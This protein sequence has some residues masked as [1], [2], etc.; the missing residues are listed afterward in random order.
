MH[1][2]P[3]PPEKSSP[4]RNSWAVAFSAGSELVVAVLLGFFCGRW[5]DG[6]F[7]TEPWLML[8]GAFLGIFLGL[9]LLIRE[10]NS[11]GRRP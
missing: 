8:G 3:P 2:S 11:S 10:T 6:R 7:G 5:A 4:R 9:Y 1:S